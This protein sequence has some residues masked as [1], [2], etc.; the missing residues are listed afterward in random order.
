M[1]NE[2][3]EVHLC[4]P[5]TLGDLRRNNSARPCLSWAFGD[6][7]LYH[8]SQSVCQRL[9]LKTLRR[10]QSAAIATH[11]LGRDGI[12]G[13]CPYDS[14]RDSRLVFH[15]GIRFSYS[16]SRRRRGRNQVAAI[17]MAACKHRACQHAQAKY[18]CSPSSEP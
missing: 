4:Y 5:Q 15:G 13:E 9:T 6:T 18:N 12:D 11:E 17:R 2:S 3:F 16:I 7:A 8:R 10:R 14:W 1:K